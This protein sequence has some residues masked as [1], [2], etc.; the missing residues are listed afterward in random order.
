MEFVVFVNDSAV[1]SFHLFVLF[2]GSGSAAQKCSN[3]YEDDDKNVEKDAAEIIVA[4]VQT[5][6]LQTLG[7][8]IA[9]LLC[10]ET[11]EPNQKTMY[12]ALLLR[13]NFL[14]SKRRCKYR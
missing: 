12:F 13:A 2:L 10:F 8:R 11:E 3:S 14:G 4:L 6:I 5:I 9:F 1:D 7:V